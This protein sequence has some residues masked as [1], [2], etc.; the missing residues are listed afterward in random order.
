[1]LLERRQI[2]SFSLLIEGGLIVIYGIWAYFHRIELIPPLRFA[3]VVLGVALTLPLLLINYVCFG[4]LSGNV[5]A[6]KG[7]RE[8]KQYVVKPLA[9]KLD[10]TSALVVSLLAGVGEELFFRGVL[11]TEFGLVLSSVAFA[12]LHFGPAIRSYYLV[13]TLY[14]LFGFYFGI[15]YHL[16]ATVW[17]PIITHATYDFVALMYLK[18]W[19]EERLANT[20]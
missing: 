3:D 16:T 17:V 2:L 15:V 4:P 12:L 18:H 11:Q 7:C 9:E 13:G 10:T 20:P 8:F 5:Q 19:P 6:L 1:M 14:L